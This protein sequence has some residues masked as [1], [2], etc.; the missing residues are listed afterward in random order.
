MLRFCTVP[1]MRSPSR[2][3]SKVSFER[4]TPFS[5]RCVLWISSEIVCANSR[6]LAAVPSYCRPNAD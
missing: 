1:D 2:S 4:A 6:G 5:A 3:E